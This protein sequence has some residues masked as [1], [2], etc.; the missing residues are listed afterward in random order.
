[1]RTILNDVQKATSGAVMAA[2]QGSKAVAAGAKQ[3]TDAGEAIRMLAESIAEAAQAAA[4]IAAS[5]EQQLGGMDQVALAIGNI[6]RA[7]TQNMASVRE[8]EQAAQNLNEL[9][10]RLEALVATS[11]NDRKTR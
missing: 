3:S 2:E 7:S 11:G 8:V 9:T 5:S 4:Q 6:Q 10:R 1:M